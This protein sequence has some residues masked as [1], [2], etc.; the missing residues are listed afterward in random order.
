[1]DFLLIRGDEPFKKDF[2]VPHE[3]PLCFGMDIE[4][5]GELLSSLFKNVHQLISHATGGDLKNIVESS[6]HF[7]VIITD[8]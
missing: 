1:M 6:T 7:E 8:T 2:L 3:R 4:Q 5:F